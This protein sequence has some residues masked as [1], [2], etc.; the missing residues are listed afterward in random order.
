MLRPIGDATKK[1]SQRMALEVNSQHRNIWLALSR[2]D[3]CGVTYHSNG[4]LGYDAYTRSSRCQTHCNAPCA[5]LVNLQEHA[6]TWQIDVCA[7]HVV[8]TLN[9]VVT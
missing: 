6:E 9:T 2:S 5:E 7:I 3:L 4:R 1:L 8:D